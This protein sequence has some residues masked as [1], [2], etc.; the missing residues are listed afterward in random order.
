LGSDLKSE[1]SNLRFQLISEPVGGSSF[2]PHGFWLAELDE[3]AAVAECRGVFG[4]GRLPGFE[5]AANFLGDIQGERPQ[6]GVEMDCRAPLL[7]AIEEEAGPDALRGAPEAGFEADSLPAKLDLV[8]AVGFGATA[9]IFDR[10][11]RAVFVDL[12]DIADPAQAVGVRPYGQSPRD[13]DTGARFAEAG[14]RLFV[15]RV[16]LGGGKIICPQPLDVD[17]CTLPRAIEVVLERGE[18]DCS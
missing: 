11:E 4:S 7:F 8:G 9:F 13:A 15:E 14:V 18:R 12:D 5:H 6:A 10:Q 16:A 2:E 1:I 17:E 3:G